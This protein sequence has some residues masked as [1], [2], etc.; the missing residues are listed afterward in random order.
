[1][2]L[3]EKFA[4][5]I[6]YKND[7][8]LELQIE[9]LKN[10]I[11]QYPNN[12]KL[13]HKLKL[14]ELGL[15]GENEIEYELKNANIG[16]YVLRDI[17]LVY[18]GITAQIDY[19]IVTPG[20]MYFVECKNL[21]GNIIINDR[22]E[23][24]RE[25]NYNGK[26]IK[27]GI[28]SPIR[29]AERHV[30]IFKKIYRE[31]KHTLLDRVFQEKRESWFKP[32]VIMANPKNILKISYAP[33]E[34][35]RKVIKSDNLVE[36]IKKDI[37]SID[38][39]LVKNKKEMYE[40]A[41]SIMENYN[42]EVTRDYESEFKEKIVEYTKTTNEATIPCND[43]AQNSIKTQEEN[44]RNNL[45]NFRK[46]RAKERNIPAYYVFNNAE[47]ERL[48]ESKPKDIQTLK[49]LKI[50]GDEKIKYHGKEIINIIVNSN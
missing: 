44:L 30:D 4:E 37:V 29:Q 17:N 40:L 46:E 18:K 1:M 14:C 35:K 8:E 45:I 19:I 11:K 49:E 42:Q 50:L 13:K 27:E 16:M 3:F 22:S 33:E 15:Q 5:T 32:L 24:I 38:K 6:F 10:L 7:S 47:L 34:I 2:G 31:R 20:Y 43:N 28:Y 9:A 39:D 25:Y 36:Y 41:F 48:L 21:I 12:E 23:F 26:K